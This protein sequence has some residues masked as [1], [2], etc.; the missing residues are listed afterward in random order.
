M[1]CSG[2]TKA[3]CAQYLNDVCETQGICLEHVY[4]ENYEKAEHKNV[5]SYE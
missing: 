4:I 3:L 5:F 2:I 1:Q